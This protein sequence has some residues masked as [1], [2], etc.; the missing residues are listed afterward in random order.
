MAESTS[1]N[2]RW[3]LQCPEIIAL[4]A[5]IIGA[6]GWIAYNR[7]LDQEIEPPHYAEVRALL[8]NKPLLRSQIESAFDDA[9][10]TKREM[11]AIRHSANHYAELVTAAQARGALQSEITPDS[12]D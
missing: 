9:A 8:R 1:G 7:G 2:L 5:C 10:I 4:S 11:R 3:L 6:G 12:T